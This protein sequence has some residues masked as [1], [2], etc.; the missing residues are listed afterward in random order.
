MLRHGFLGVRLGLLEMIKPMCGH[1]CVVV[2][3]ADHASFRIDPP[4]ALAFRDALLPGVGPGLRKA[5]H[6]L[7]I[8]SSSKAPVRPWRPFRPALWGGELVVL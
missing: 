7:K 2:G 1:L 5:Q 4:D 3:P 6:K 8:L